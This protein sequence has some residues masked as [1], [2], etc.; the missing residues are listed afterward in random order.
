M[1]GSTVALSMT[2][3][4]LAGFAITSHNQGTGSAVTLDNVAVTPGELAP[5]GICPTGWQCAD[6]G[7]ATPAGGQ[8]LSSGTWTLRGGG[9]DIWGTAD[10][11]HYVWQS[12]AGDGVLN[13]GVVSQTNTDPWAKA[14]V[15]FRTS[16]DPG[17]P[18]YALFVTPGNGLAVQYRTAQ[19]ATTSQ[20]L[21]PGTVPI[22]VQVVRTGTTFTA[23]TSP[24]G[25]TWSG[26]PG[27]TVSL[28]NLSGALLTG[29]AVTSHNVFL[30]SNVVMNS[31][32]TTP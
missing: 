29:L 25:T 16:T 19:G 2:G 31:V 7:G 8:D 28:P 12:M 13:A 10:A 11:F 21:M 15:M 18:Y 23:A 32:V 20:V 6:V 26:V 22:H 17:S 1:A 5:P 3:P 9:G 14:G 27:A 30:L 24:D 4:L